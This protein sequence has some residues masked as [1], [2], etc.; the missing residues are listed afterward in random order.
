MGIGW[1]WWKVGQR[2]VGVIS[3]EKVDGL[4][5]LK[6]HIMEISR[7]VTLVHGH[8]TECEDRA[9]ILGQN[10]QNVASL[11]AQAFLPKLNFI[12]QKKI[13]EKM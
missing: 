10:S 6:G 3:F 7:D 1:V 11:F 9:R 4:C 2:I 8:R 5:G 12:F 13:Y